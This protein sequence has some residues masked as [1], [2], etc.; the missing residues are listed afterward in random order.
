[1]SEVYDINR[2]LILFVM[3]EMN[4]YGISKQKI[5][6]YTY[7]AKELEKA[8]REALSGTVYM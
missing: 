6:L 7:Y 1:M 3:T 8:E 4:S 2:M 5:S